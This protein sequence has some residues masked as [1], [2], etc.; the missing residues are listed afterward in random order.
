MCA[1]SS[2][3]RV[4]RFPLRD[5]APGL[6]EELCCQ[7]ERVTSRIEKD[8]PMLR[9]GLLCRNSG[10]QTHRVSLRNV[11]VVH[12][13][14]QMHLFRHGRIRPRRRDVVLHLDSDQ[15][16][17][18]HLDSVELVVA[19]RNFATKERRPEVSEG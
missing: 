12:F 13:Q 19:M 8:P 4:L 6:I 1:I 11:E 3:C 5:R 17:S 14:V 16:V 9:I 10:A 2:C 15:P 18:V 7:A